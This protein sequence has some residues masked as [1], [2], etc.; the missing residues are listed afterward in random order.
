[1]YRPDGVVGKPEVKSRFA[2]PNFLTDGLPVIR[3]E[4]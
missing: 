2:S 3:A 1:V 4:T